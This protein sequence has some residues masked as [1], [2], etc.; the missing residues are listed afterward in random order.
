M[1]RT[2]KEYRRS[3]KMRFFASEIGSGGTIESP[4]ELLSTVEAD[5]W[6]DDGACWGV[7]GVPICCDEGFIDG[8]VKGV[9]GLF[10]EGPLESKDTLDGVVCNMFIFII[11]IPISMKNLELWSKP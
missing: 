11:F 3:F 6:T 7:T 9:C 10:E 1:K 5:V 4:P 8:I 2:I